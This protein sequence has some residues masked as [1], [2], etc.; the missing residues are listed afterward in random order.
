[1]LRLVMRACALALL[2]LGCGDDGAGGGITVTPSWTQTLAPV[3]ANVVGHNAVWSRGGLGLWDDTANTPVAPVMSLVGD[4]HPGVLRFPGGTRAMRYH[5]DQAIGPIAQRTPQCDPFTGATD[6]THYGLDEFLQVAEQAGADVTLVAPWVDGTPEEAAALVAYVNADA[7]STATLGVDAN[8]KDWGTAGSWAA[9]RAQNGHAAPYGVKYLEIGNE[10]YHDLPVGPA[11]SCGRMSTFRQDE[12]WVGTTKIPT[13][14]ADHATQ[15]ARYATAVHAVDPT[16]RVGASAYSTYDGHSNAADAISDL[17]MQMA[18]NDP[19]D[20]RLVMDGGAFDFFILH[21]YDF[22]TLDFRITLADKLRKTI[23]DLHALAPDKGIAITEYGFLFDGG[24][25]LNALVSADVVRVAI[26]EHVLLALRHVLIE[27]RTDEPFADS[28][29]IAG[30][31]HQLAPGY[32]VMRLLARNLQAVA[33]PVTSSDPDVTALAT[34]NDAGDT[35]AIVVIDRRTK[36]GATR[37]ISIALP[38]HFSGTQT[39]LTAPQL[40][41]TDVTL[42][43]SPASASGTLNLQLPPHSLILARLAKI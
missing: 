32:Q 29:A 3:G 40:L 7:S 8:G 23:D 35:I 17:D 12:R 43:D 15:V 18:T 6:A 21:P 5:F 22:T 31:D 33:V 27:D 28:A 24:S 19:W 36:A 16:I 14:A 2:A 26:E 25:L 9:R 39:L 41:S 37:T 30:P 11:V 10:Q 20:R 13:T 42:T 38:G 34:R 4:L 1:M